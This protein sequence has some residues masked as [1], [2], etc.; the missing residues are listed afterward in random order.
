MLPLLLINAISAAGDIYHN[1]A[2]QAAENKAA[3][4]AAAATTGP[5]P[6][7]QSFP[8]MLQKTVA[9][10]LVA[11]P[12]ADQIATTQKELTTQL[13]HSNDVV[14][15]MN[16]SGAKGPFQIKLDANGA[17]SLHAADGTVKPLSLSPEMKTIAQKLYL[18]GSSTSRV[19][20]P[21]TTASTTSLATHP[22]T[23]VTSAK[24]VILSQN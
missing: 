17:A 6:V 14:S 12:T 19:T 13:Y 15:A 8:A 2:T 23:S 1:M 21:A 7:G 20:T 10:T 3:K 24:S 18:L 9:S 11:T 22:T 5:T 16:A 4:E